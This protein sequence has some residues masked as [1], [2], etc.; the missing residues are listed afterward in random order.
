MVYS[1]LADAGVPYDDV[2]AYYD[3][4]IA[5]A[6]PAE[7]REFARLF[8]VPGMG[9][10]F[11]GPGVT[12]IGQPFSSQVPANPAGDALMALVAWTEKGLA[13]NQLIAN[14]PAGDGSPE[15]DRP[16]CAYPAF[17]EYKGGNPARA[18]SFACVNHAAGASQVPA[19]RYLN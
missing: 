15:Q 4:V 19:R 1:G 13:P 6:G 7:G 5:A 11:G 9:H 17:P 8:L 16:V 10:C 3:R 18:A 12:N 2:I 14:K